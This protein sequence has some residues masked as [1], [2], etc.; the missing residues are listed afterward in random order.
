MHLGR[1]AKCEGMRSHTDIRG[2][3]VGLGS[4]VGGI[5]VVPCQIERHTGVSGNE[6]EVGFSA[7]V[8]GG[9]AGGVGAE[10]GEETVA[11]VEDVGARVGVDA[12]EVEGFQSA[13][14]E[15]AVNVIGVGGDETGVELFSGGGR[16]RGEGWGDVGAGVCDSRDNVG[17]EWFQ[18]WV[19]IVEER[20]YRRDDVR[21]KDM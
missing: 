9:D 18:V 14:P 10:G 17:F 3:H 8:R 4:G 7:R 15:V 2:T 19:G 21:V 11:V 12:G 13:G 6:D 5:R 1:R 16:E 20:S